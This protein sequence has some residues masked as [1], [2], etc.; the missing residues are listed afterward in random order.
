MPLSA[1]DL[2]RQTV[3]HLQVIFVTTACFFV[4]WISFSKQTIAQN[5][6]AVPAAAPPI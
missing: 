4:G 5:D 6:D 1:E 2:E 3:N